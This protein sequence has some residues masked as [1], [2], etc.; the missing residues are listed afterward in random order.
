MPKFCDNGHQMENSWTDCPYCARTGYRSVAGGTLGKTR[1]EEGGPGTATAPDGPAFD[2]RKTVPLSSVRRTPV[3]GWLVALNGAH[4]GDDFRLREGKNTIGSAEGSDITLRDHAVSSNHANVTY[5]DGK[6]SVVDLDST[7]GT[8][9]N[10]DA[11]QVA[12]AEL[13]D[14]DVIRVG[15]TALKFK[16]L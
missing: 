16:C 10:D 9:L 1:P 13:L 11:E 8:F 2:P 15:E 3:V 6:F 14:N 5:R 7:N 4:K 12:R